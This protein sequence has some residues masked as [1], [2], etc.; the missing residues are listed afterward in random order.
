MGFADRISLEFIEAYEQL[1]GG[2]YDALLE[3]AVRNLADLWTRNVMGE[4]LFLSE[5]GSKR[6]AA[7]GG[8]SIGAE[9]RRY[10]GQQLLGIVECP[11]C[12]EVVFSEATDRGNLL[13]VDSIGR[14]SHGSV[15]DPETYVREADTWRQS[16]AA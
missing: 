4:P 1:N 5:Y 6:R 3:W 14:Y 11:G 10:A 2:E 13:S 15:A 12:L 7:M 9:L 8:H 16:E